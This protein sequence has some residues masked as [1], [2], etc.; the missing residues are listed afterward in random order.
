[1]PW[2]EEA[3]DEW[4]YEDL[5]DLLELTPPKDV[6]F[7]VADWNAKQEV[8]KHLEEQANVSSEYRMRQGKG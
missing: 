6:L 8:R 2:P 4:F 7:I 3:E 1:M 5:Q